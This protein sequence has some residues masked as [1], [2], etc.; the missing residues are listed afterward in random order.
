MVRSTLVPFGR[1]WPRLLKLPC[2]IISRESWQNGAAGHFLTLLLPSR[3]CVE[4]F[5]RRAPSFALEGRWPERLRKADMLRVERAMGTV[6][7]PANV[8]SH[9]G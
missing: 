6:H 3:A 1:G 8:R 7:V 2:A 5:G 4:D 9:T